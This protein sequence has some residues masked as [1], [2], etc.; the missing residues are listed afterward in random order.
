MPGAETVRPAELQKQ[1]HIREEQ[2]RRVLQEGGRVLKFTNNGG[3]LYFR[4]Y[5]PAPEQLTWN[6]L[7]EGLRVLFS[8][9][10]SEVHICYTDADGTKIT[11]NDSSGLKIMFDD[12]RD[13]DVIHIE[14]VAEKAPL[15][16]V[17]PVG[18]GG[19]SGGS[20]SGQHVPDMEMPMPSFDHAQSGFPG[21]APS[22]PHTALSGRSGM[23]H[24]LPQG[25]GPVPHSVQPPISAGPVPSYA[26]LNAS[27]GTL[28]PPRPQ[29]PLD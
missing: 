17:V 23:P 22:R 18:G 1:L 26:Q 24:P 3:E 14:V 4:Y 20:G 21:V 11:V 7:V 13:S 9:A 29:K 28:P 15:H 19:G 8:I 27:T 2:R 16:G 10:H 5:F 12:T 25:P 6:K